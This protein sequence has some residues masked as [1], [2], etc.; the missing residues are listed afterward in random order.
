MHQRQPVGVG[1]RQIDEADVGRALG[2]R[3]LEGAGAA[4]AE[5]V[6]SG[7]FQ[8]VRQEAADFRF[9]VEDGDQ[10]LVI[11]RRPRAR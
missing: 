9:V 10:R 4:K 7:L 6:E 11:A 3:G 2:Q 8:H 5:R 1:Q